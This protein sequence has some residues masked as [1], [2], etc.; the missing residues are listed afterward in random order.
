MV[1]PSRLGIK[2]TSRSVQGLWDRVIA[3]SDR[4]RIED[5]RAGLDC[6]PG[7]NFDCSQR[8]IPHRRPHSGRYRLKTIAASN[9]IDWDTGAFGYPP[10]TV[11]R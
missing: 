9:R 10:E 3:R 6:G 11:F 1:P 7:A 5:P 4:F 2:S 8:S